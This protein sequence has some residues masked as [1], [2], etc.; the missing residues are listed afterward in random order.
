MVTGLRVWKTLPEEI[1]TSQTLLT[2][3]TP[4]EKLAVRKI[5]P[6]HYHLS[7]QFLFNLELGPTL[8]D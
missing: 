1:T 7:L 6:G 4:S 2:Y 3:L 8:I 5:I